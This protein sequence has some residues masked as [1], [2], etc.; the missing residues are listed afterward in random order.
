MKQ[1]ELNL[2]PRSEHRED[3]EP[4][5]YRFSDGALI[6]EIEGTRYI[7]GFWN[8]LFGC[9]R[10]DPKTNKTREIIPTWRILNPHGIWRDS[11]EIRFAD[12]RLAAKTFTKRWRYEANAAFAGYMSNIPRFARTIVAPLGPYQW[13]GLDLIWQCPEFAQFLDDEIYNDTIQYV[14]ACFALADARKLSRGE[15]K[16]LAQSM[17][18]RKR[19]D[20]LEDL[21]R[22]PVPKAALKVLYR[23]GAQPCSAKI[24][25]ALFEAITTEG[26]DKVLFHAKHINPRGILSVYH[27]PETLLAPNIARM[28]LT[29]FSDAAAI[30]AYEE[31]YAN[32]IV[33]TSELVPL[34]PPEM[35]KALNASLSCIRSPEAFADW[36]DTW[37]RKLQEAVLIPPPPFPGTDRLIPITSARSLRREALRMKNCLKMMVSDVLEGE[38]YFYHWHG[39]EPATVMIARDSSYAWTFGEA[40]GPQNAALSPQTIRYIEHLIERLRPIS[41]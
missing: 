14:Y 6:E 41:G 16:T 11:Q 28:F 9:W 33:F 7:Y 26:P 23:L 24:Y 10:L 32:T 38:V 8:K 27:F 4:W 2:T 20:L 29:G 39:N 13:L 12:S 1:M 36:L 21:A 40:M 5:Q 34:A 15:R 19:R 37:S 30:N 22:T 25:T 18:S 3:Q 17:M 31:E 35:Q